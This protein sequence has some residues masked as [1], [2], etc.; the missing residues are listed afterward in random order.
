MAQAHFGDQARL[1][2]AAPERMH[3]HCG[4]IGGQSGNV[5]ALGDAAYGETGFRETIDDRVT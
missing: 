3:I 1:E 2:M 4:E 5:G